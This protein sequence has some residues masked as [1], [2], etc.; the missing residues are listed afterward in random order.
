MALELEFGWG[1]AGRSHLQQ[2]A[3]VVVV[4]DVLSFCTCVEVAVARGASV[5][6]W[7][8]S[9][10]FA[11]EW[12]SRH[13]ALPAAAQRSRHQPSLSPLSL[14]ELPAQ[15]K[16]VLPSPNGAELAHRAASGAA[17]VLAGCIR[18]AAAVADAAAATASDRVLVLAAGE[19][20]PD[21]SLRPAL[22]DLVG[23]GAVLARLPGA[24]SP[25]AAGAIAAYSDPQVRDALARCH[26]ARELVDRGFRDDVRFAL[27]PDA[28]TA[29]P[30]IRHP[31]RH[32][33]AL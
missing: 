23:A 20:W 31:A 22:E 8:A 5:I 30:A 26:S 9:R 6:P 33:A 27:R 12:A 3:D 25:D 21:G 16:L 13:G 24:R 14:T 15:S 28:S 32:F 17:T 1:E 11:A 4:V 7:A 19:R 10:R 2:E 18:N 29:V